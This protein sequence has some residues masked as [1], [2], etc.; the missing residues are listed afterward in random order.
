[1]REIMVGIACLIASWAVVSWI[2]IKI[3]DKRGK[4]DER[5]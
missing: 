4:Y 5:I 3:Q 2:V 1:M